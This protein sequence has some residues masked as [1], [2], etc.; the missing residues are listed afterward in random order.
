M[1]AGFEVEHEEDLSDVKLEAL[2][3]DLLQLQVGFGVSFDFIPPDSL[4]LI[5]YE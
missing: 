2:N 3:R 4:N 1:D 5:N